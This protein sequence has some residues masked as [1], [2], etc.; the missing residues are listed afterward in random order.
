MTNVDFEGWMFLFH[1][2]KNNGF[3]FVAHHL[4]FI[5]KGANQYLQVINITL[6][7]H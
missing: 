3:F 5:L 1:P 6:F 7:N 4:T 2:Y